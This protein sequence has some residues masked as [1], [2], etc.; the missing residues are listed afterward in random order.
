[1]GAITDFFD[2]VNREIDAALDALVP[3]SDVEPKQLHEAI[4]WS[5]FAGGK[6]IRPAILIAV[7]RAFGAA[8]GD[9][10]QTAAAVEMI[11]TYS[12]I[13][14]DLPAM[15]DDDLRRGKATCHRQFGEATAILAGDALQTFAFKAV[16]DDENLSP[17]VRVKLV[18]ILAAA[19][20]TPDGM[21][22]GQQLDL[23][24]E[25]K[26]VSIRHLEQIHR[27]K[28]GALISAAANAGAI[29]GGACHEELDAVGK[30]AENLGLLFQ[31]TDDLLDVTQRT[32]TLGKT[33]GKDATAEKATYP[34]HY[35][36]EKTMAMAIAIRDDARGA[37]L[38]VNGDTE[39]LQDLADLILE[40]RR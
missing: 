36:V 13:H 38:S 24:A 2:E 16:A 33:A 23:V 6:R 25:G 28:T 21:V 22:S 3:R 14:D 19:S 27:Q 1:M 4:R 32:A 15:D 8:L 7:G 20:S 39:L 40:R 9:L 34:A 35:G 5:L 12:L 31:I 26:A 29:I 37:L 18:S 10:I 17:A 11:H 30:Y